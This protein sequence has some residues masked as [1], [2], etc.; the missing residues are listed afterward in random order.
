[1]K[2]VGFFD[3]HCHILFGVD[4][5]AADFETAS[6]MLDIAY[7]DGIR[8]I[9][10]T[11][12]CRPGKSLDKDVADSAFLALEKYVS[13]KNY[14]IA[15]KMGAE[16]LCSSSPLNDILSGEV[17]TLCSSSYVLCEFHEYADFP[18][19]KK[20]INDIVAAGYFPVIAHPERYDCIKKQPKLIYELSKICLVQ[21]NSSLFVPSGKRSLLKNI[22]KKRIIRFVLKSGMDF[23]VSSDAHDTDKR[24]PRI[25]EIYSY[26]YKKRGA[27]FADR[28]FF[29]IPGRI[30]S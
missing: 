11:P 1:M 8:H 3:L 6:E 23:V 17:R 18:E 30:F 24:A 16:I 19:I 13:D 20:R 2:N 28:I 21:F 25:S 15:L 27:E 22:R 7:A 4:D 29:E 12:H 5:G 10:L 26:I 9:C 14:N